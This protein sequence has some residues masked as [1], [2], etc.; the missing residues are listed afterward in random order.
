MNKFRKA[1]LAVSVAVTTP[2]LFAGVAGATTPPTAGEVVGSMADD[3][4]AQ[5]LGIFSTN[6]GKLV[7]LAALAFGV[8]WVMRV[9]RKGGKSAT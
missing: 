1:L 2:V 8:N 4:I 9:T 3:G 6:A 5:V 7:V